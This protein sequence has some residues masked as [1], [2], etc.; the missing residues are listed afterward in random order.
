M[1]NNDETPPLIYT[2]EGATDFSELNTL[3]KHAGTN[4]KKLVIN[5]NGDIDKKA[6]FKIAKAVHKA[7]D[8]KIVIEKDFRLEG[9]PIGNDFFNVFEFVTQ[10]ALSFGMN[11][12]LDGDIFSYLPSKLKYLGIYSH[13]EDLSIKGK[14]KDK[15]VEHLDI[16]YEV[17]GLE[18]IASIKGLK[19]LWLEELD[20][21]NADSLAACGKLKELRLANLKIKTLDPLTDSKIEVLHLANV[22]GIKSFD[23]LSGVEKLKEIDIE[24]QRTFTK[25]PDLSKLSNLK[26]VALGDTPKLEDISGLIKAK[27]LKEVLLHSKVMK[28]KDFKQILDL[29]TIKS[30]Q[31]AVA[32]NDYCYEELEHLL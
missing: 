4:D 18:E 10:Y 15:Q 11:S 16:N 21:V 7:D 30:C 3:V 2:T 27:G 29:P 31:V 26:S 6:L 23:F 1:S 22:K 13:F 12:E 8:L 28:A 32:E 14:L 17:Q 5:F 19:T 20:K 25:F 24:E 9:K